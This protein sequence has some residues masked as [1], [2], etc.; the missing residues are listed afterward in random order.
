LVEVHTNLVHDRRLRRAFSLTYQDLEGQDQTP[1]ALLVVAATHGA[2]HFFAWLRHVVDLCQAARA[3]PIEEEGRL[4]AL[5][6]RTGTRFAAIVGLT[7]ANRVMGEPRCLDIAQGLGSIRH[8]HIEKILVRGGD[9]T[10]TSTN[11]LLY[12]TWRRVLFRELLR[13]GALG[14]YRGALS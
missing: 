10:A 4:E 2:T 12:N 1:A 7:L 9:L 6:S 3:L 8:T 14:E 11:W 13:Y 5:T